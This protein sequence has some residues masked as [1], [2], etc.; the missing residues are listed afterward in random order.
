MLDRCALALMLAVVAAASRPRASG[1][2]HDLLAVGAV[3]EETRDGRVERRLVLGMPEGAAREAYEAIL[4]GPAARAVVQGTA[5]AVPAR[6]AT[7]R[8]K[9]IEVRFYGRGS[10]AGRAAVTYD[11]AAGVADLPG[12]DALHDAAA[13]L[14]GLPGPVTGAAA[15]VL[16]RTDDVAAYADALEA[17]A[18]V[19]A[20]AAAAEALRTAADESLAPARRTTALRTLQSLG[21]RKAFGEAFERAAASVDAAL[22]RPVE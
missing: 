6:P 1:G 7:G 21:G 5:V 20:G 8:V 10:R 9:V 12:A 19:D 2:A 17:L 16:L 22:R 3:V 15:R 11:A 13:V 14:A 18:A 4:R